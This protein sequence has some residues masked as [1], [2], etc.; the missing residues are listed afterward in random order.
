MSIISINNIDPPR[1]HEKESSALRQPPLKLAEHA[2][3]EEAQTKI[4]AKT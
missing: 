3:K 1:S 4:I 2:I